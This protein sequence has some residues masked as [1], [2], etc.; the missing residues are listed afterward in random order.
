MICLPCCCS[1]TSIE[2]QASTCH[3]SRKASACTCGRGRAGAPIGGH[4]LYV[5]CFYPAPDGLLLLPGAWQPHAVQ[6]QPE[7]SLA[8]FLILVSDPVSRGLAASGSPVPLWV[9]RGVAPRSLQCRRAAFVETLSGVLVARRGAPPWQATMARHAVGTAL[10]PQ[11]M[12]GHRCFDQRCARNSGVP[13]LVKCC[14]LHHVL[15]QGQAGN[16]FHERHI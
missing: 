7:N 2:Q 8:P 6:C 4:R 13:C 3:P 16:K 9:S 5:F 1:N 15:Q 10:V 11:R 12:L 14:I